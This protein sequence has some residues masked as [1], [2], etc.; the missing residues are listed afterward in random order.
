MIPDKSHRCVERKR[1]LRPVGRRRLGGQSLL[2]PRE[3]QFQGLAHDLGLL[4]AGFAKARRSIHA[5]WL[6]FSTEA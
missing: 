3:G 2:K 1:L 4:S 5:S 6:A